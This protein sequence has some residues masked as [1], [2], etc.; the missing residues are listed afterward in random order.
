M[1]WFLNLGLTRK[2]IPTVDIKFPARKSPSLNR[3]SRHVFPT[4]ESPNNITYWQKHMVL[5]ITTYLKYMGIEL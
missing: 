1:Y 3:M 2:S 5:K 4:P